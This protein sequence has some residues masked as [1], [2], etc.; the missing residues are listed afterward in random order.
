M[1]KIHFCKSSLSA[2]DYVL[3]FLSLL[4]V[5]CTIIL[6]VIFWIDAP[7]TVPVHYNIYGIA[8]GFG[9]KTTLIILPVISIVTYVGLT[10]LNKF[11]YIFNFPVKVTAQNRL[12]LYKNA[13]RMVR[14]NKLIICLLFAVIVWQQIGIS[15]RLNNI[16][17]FI[18]TACLMICFIVYVVK[19]IRVGKS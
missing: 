9:N 15:N 8:D 18:L 12:I 19:M 7:K 1:K 3:E 14:W 13:T 5:L 17:L 6:F 2:I 10:L 16:F 11:P 4:S